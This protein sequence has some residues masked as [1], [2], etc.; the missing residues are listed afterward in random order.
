VR[1][2]SAAVLLAALAAGCGEPLV[3]LDTY[4]SPL[5]TLTGYFTPQPAGGVAPLRVGVLW[6]DP[7]G[8]RDDLPAPSAGA[9]FTSD[10]VD[11]FEL[12]VFSPPPPSA[13]RRYPFA[14]SSGVALAFAFGELVV[15]EDNDGDGQ[16]T[17]ASR[18]NGSAIVGPDLFR[19]SSS[20]R[21]LLYLEQPGNP[22][23]GSVGAAW[24]VLFNNGQGYRLGNVDC[25]VPDR[26]VLRGVPDT[27]G[28][29]M[30][31]TNRGEA[32]RTFSRA[33]LR[34]AVTAP[35]PP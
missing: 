4:Q 19:G 34:S 16:F 9:V 28:V 13:I 31:L 22:Q 1:G 32:Q 23:A 29:E 27:A 20:N 10:L 25:T 3:P 15:Y 14:T 12:Q 24:P 8:L 2:A 21:V 18:A 5:M 6:V 26:P 7:A 35:T 17:V 11:T 33:C 30:S